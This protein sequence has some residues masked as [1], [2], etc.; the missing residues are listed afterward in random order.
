[1]VPLPLGGVVVPEPAAPIVPVVPVPAL[2]VLA[3]VL[4]LLLGLVVPADLPVAGLADW[5]VLLPQ[6]ITC[7][8]SSAAGTITSFV[9]I[10]TSLTDPA[11]THGVRGCPGRINAEGLSIVNLNRI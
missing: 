2:P 10:S 9:V 11:A 4:E 7:A 1:M 8:S 3:G 5:S 6:P